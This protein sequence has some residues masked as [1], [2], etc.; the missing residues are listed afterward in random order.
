LINYYWFLDLLKCEED[1]L[2]EHSL[3]NCWLHLV[4]GT[5]DRY[6]YFSDTEISEVIYSIIAEICHEK[7]IYIEEMF[8]N[9]EHVHLLLALPVNLTIHD[10]MQTLKGLSSHIINDRNLFGTQFRWARGYAAFSISSG[11]IRRVASYIK[12]QKENHS[13]H[14]F[15]KEWETFQLEFDKN[16]KG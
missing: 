10:L 5:K 8:I 3:L 4:W 12:N 9:P 13:R 1:I 7:G 15:S 16:T 2:P 6:P 14:S 11:N